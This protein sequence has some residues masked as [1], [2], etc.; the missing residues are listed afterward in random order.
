MNLRLKPQCCSCFESFNNGKFSSNKIQKCIICFHISYFIS[1]SVFVF[2]FA[3]GEFYPRLLK[4]SH[5]ICNHCAKKPE[6]ICNECACGQDV[7]A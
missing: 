6:L 4:C 5:S 2:P 7:A 3:K 1:P